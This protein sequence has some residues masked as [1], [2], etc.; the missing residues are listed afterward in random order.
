MPIKEKTC[1]ICGGPLVYT[2]ADLNDTYC[3]H[4]NKETGFMQR[5][6]TEKTELDLKL[7][8]LN[9]FRESD[10][11]KQLD[12]HTRFLLTAQSRAMHIYSDI[13]AQRIS[14]FKQ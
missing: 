9:A 14:V 11:Y 5:V 6:V 10:T 2:S 1:S 13:L 3:K 12:S 8:K 7:I 4:C